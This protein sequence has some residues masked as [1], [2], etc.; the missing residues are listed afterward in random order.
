MKIYNC[1]SIL[2][3]VHGNSTTTPIYDATYHTSTKGR[4][5]QW[6]KKVRKMPLF[7]LRS[8]NID[9]IYL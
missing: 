9:Y 5:I 3:K 8:Q 4:A 1:R 6:F 2:Q 7:I